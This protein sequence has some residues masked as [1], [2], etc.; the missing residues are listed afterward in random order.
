MTGAQPLEVRPLDARAEAAL[1][2]AR[3]AA[4]R[5]VLQRAM[6]D[7]VRTFCLGFKERSW[8]E[9]DFA[10]RVGAYVGTA[11]TEAG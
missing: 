5:F 3:H 4:W 2:G 6:A 9:Q 10:R 8:G 11:H 7:P 1:R